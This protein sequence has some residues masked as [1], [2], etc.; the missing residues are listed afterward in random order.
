[1]TNQIGKQLKEIR[2]SLGFGTARSFYQDYL[3][4]KTQLEFNYSY[5]MKIEG[6]RALPSPAIITSICDLL[7]PDYQ[8]S[9]IRVYCQ[10]LFPKQADLFTIPKKFIEKRTI[11]PP[12]AK[13]EK[14]T[15]TK[16]RY[17]TES[18]VAC[19]A[20]SKEHYFLFLLLTLSR[21]PVNLQEL[22]IYLG[23][24]DTTAL[25]KDLNES[26]LA[27][28]ESEF[29]ECSTK[30][31]KFP[32]ADTASLKKLYESI[33][34]WNLDFPRKA[35]FEQVE[36]KMMIRRV[37]SRYISLLS[38]QANFMFDFMRAA[39]EVQQDHNNEV[40]MLNF[41]LSRGSLPG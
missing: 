21:H 6:G 9:I 18:Q 39:D 29:A 26:K 11:K 38:S 35:N 1:M 19:L 16:Q 30:E 37:S 27:H 22:K 41:S 32:K 31:M 34:A 2:E 28:V 20:R 33:D 5:Y 25:L 23:I 4:K 24:A 17:L 8:R 14:F 12:K 13:S 36:E 7:S 15:L 10:C 3:C 40:V